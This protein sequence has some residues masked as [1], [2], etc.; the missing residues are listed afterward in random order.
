MA[1]R[2]I[3]RADE[4][5]VPDAKDRSRGPVFPSHA[6]GAY[7]PATNADPVPTLMLA[8]DASILSRA[9]LKALAIAGVPPAAVLAEVGRLSRA[10]PPDERTPEALED[11]F[12]TAAEHISADRDIGARLGRLLPPM[13]GHVIE[14][15]YTSSRTFGGALMRT[16]AYQQLLNRE[17][18]LR[19]VVTA[20][21]C[22]LCDES[23]RRHN[24][25]LAECF[26]GGAIRFLRDAS[27]GA[28]QPR[29]IHFM[30]KDGA[31]AEEYRLLF[32]CPVLL[33]CAQTRLYFNHESLGHEA[34][35]VDLSLQRTHERLADERVEEQDRRALTDSVTR[36]ISQSL[37]TGDISI[38][39]V[40]KRLGMT[41]RRL[42]QELAA[43]DTTYNKLLN[44]YR[45]QLACRLLTATEEPVE[46]IVGLTGYSE[47][48]A[49]Y[50][51]FRRWTGVTPVAWRQQR[52]GEMPPV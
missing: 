41:R 6:P 46:T 33:G 20:D 25:H 52:R 32:G 22:Y 1:E 38:E 49:F 12:W 35:Y 21:A 14:Y 34:W 16:L 48:S 13:R 2:V 10:L 30:H 8:E 51:A 31:N 37:E 43:V 50:R 40:A 9:R 4:H 36:L 23:G 42:Q 7:M 26:A 45:L 18:Q 15:F 44:D 47:I 3:G 17:L 24:R 11:A 5:R 27:D 29:E 19:L 39:S 28:F